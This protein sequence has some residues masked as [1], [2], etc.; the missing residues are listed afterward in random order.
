MKWK[1]KLDLLLIDKSAEL[2][3]RLEQQEVAGETEI[4]EATISRW[5][6]TEGFQRLDAD[7][8]FKL[9]QY[10]GVHWSELVELAP[11]DEKTEDPESKTRL[12]PV[13]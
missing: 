11:E 8:V 10:L 3:R 4:P 6:N 9:S 1:P 5:M 12:A 13:A 2:R 7:T